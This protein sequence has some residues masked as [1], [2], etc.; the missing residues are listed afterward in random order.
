VLNEIFNVLSLFP[1]CSISHVRGHQETA[2]PYDKLPVLAKLNVDADSLANSFC[3]HSTHQSHSP[4]FPS[5]GLQVDTITGTINNHW[6]RHL[7]SSFHL[8]E[9]HDYLLD[10]YN[11]NNTVLNS[12]DWASLRMCLKKRNIP[13]ILSN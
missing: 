3:T 6:K 4:L 5:S 9:Y 2:I 10:K 12:I 7:H 13:H 11:W 1:R 8:Q